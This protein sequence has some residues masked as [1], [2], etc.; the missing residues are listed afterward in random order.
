MK[1]NFSLIINRGKIPGAKKCQVEVVFGKGRNSKRIFMR[2]RGV[3]DLAAASSVINFVDRFVYEHLT[4]YLEGLCDCSWIGGGRRTFLTS[5]KNM[6]E[7]MVEVDGSHGEG[8]GQIIRN[9]VAYACLLR[10]KLRVT[11]IRAGRPNP[12]LASQHL[13]SILALLRLTQASSPSRLA[14][15]VTEFELDGTCV[16]GKKDGVYTTVDLKTAGSTSL[17]IQ[18][19]LPYLLTLTSP[20]Q[21]RIIGGTHVLKAPNFDYLSRIFVPT[22]NRFLNYNIDIRMDRPGYFPRGGG[23]LKLFVNR[24]DGKSPTFNHFSL[25]ERGN[26]V[27]VHAIL[28]LTPK[29]ASR[30]NEFCNKISAD[31]RNIEV[32]TVSYASVEYYLIFD[33][34][35]VGFYYLAEGR[36]PSASDVYT[37]IDYV[38][39]RLECFLKSSAVVDEFMQD[40]LIMYMA[41]AKFYNP[42]GSSEMYTGPLTDHTT[43]AIHVSNLFLQHKC[44]FVVTPIDNGNTFSVKV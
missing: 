26:L 12:G 3:I 20:S 17:C 4:G 15:G 38:K 18:C 24:E 9:A 22:M 5:V 40:Q 8:G 16:H 42:E 13:E 1:F 35:Y 2:L 23:V 32:R 11:N 44:S 37:G 41:L 28:N 19:I 6:D 30:T 31:T 25:I 43:S 7:V 29:L 14:K 27:E 36:N 21:I 39:N 34:S 10:R 33:K